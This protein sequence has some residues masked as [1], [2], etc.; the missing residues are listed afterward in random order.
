MVTHVKLSPSTIMRARLLCV[1]CIIG[2]CFIA[3]ASAKSVAQSIPHTDRD[4]AQAVEAAE[5]AHDIQRTLPGEAGEQRVD[6]AAPQ[7]VAPPAEKPTPPWLR[8]VEAVIRVLIKVI[9]WLL[10]LLLIAIVLYRLIHR[11]RTTPSPSHP[12]TLA[13]HSTA[14]TEDKLAHARALAQEG[15]FDEAVHAILGHAFDHLSQ[16]T[17]QLIQRASTAR[18]IV[19][20]LTLAP[21]TAQGLQTLVAYVEKSRYAGHTLRLEDYTLCH[22]TVMDI[23]DR[24]IQ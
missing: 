16:R 6:R 15:R 5:T 8:R 11:N 24:P 17:G 18:E 14:P 9:G 1:L 20:S 10:T 22:H 3:L 13:Q 19:A 2:L 4:I 12:T 7:A 23:C 21:T